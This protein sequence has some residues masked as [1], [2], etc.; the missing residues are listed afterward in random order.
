MDR[1]RTVREG[2]QVDRFPSFVG[3]IAYRSRYP[4][5][6]DAG[7]WFRQEKIEHILTRVQI[8]FW[9]QFVNGIVYLGC[10]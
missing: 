4:E 3:E 5:F 10:Y 9:Y 2:F 6:I 8:L 1:R 7:T